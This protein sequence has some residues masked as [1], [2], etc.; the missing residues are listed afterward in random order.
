MTLFEG[1]ESTREAMP[2]LTRR[3]TAVMDLFTQDH[4]EVNEGTVAEECWPLI[5]HRGGGVRKVVNALERKHLIRMDEWLD[6]EAGYRLGL[7]DLGRLYLSRT[8]Q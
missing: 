7:T 4:G 5:R 8:T 1:D 2:L 3:E 6:E